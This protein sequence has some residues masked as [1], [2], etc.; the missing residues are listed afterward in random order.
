M[1]EL[2]VSYL[3]LA[4]PITSS[5]ATI[6]ADM[7]RRSVKISSCDDRGFCQSF[8]ERENALKTCQ[9][10]PG[11]GYP[12]LVNYEVGY[13]RNLERMLAFG[14]SK[15]VYSVRNDSFIKTVVCSE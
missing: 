13:T 3:L 15:E 2:I 4:Y 9:S 7:S 10:L 12:N 1:L 14:V 5:K 11:G 8:V 6:Y